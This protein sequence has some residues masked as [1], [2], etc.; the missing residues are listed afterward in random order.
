MNTEVTNFVNNYEIR[1]I[2]HRDRIERYVRTIKPIQ[3]SECEHCVEQDVQS[4]SDGRWNFKHQLELRRLQS[5]ETNQE[6]DP[7]STIRSVVRTEEY[8][9]RGFKPIREVSPKSKT[10]PNSEYTET[11]A[12]SRTLEKEEITEA[13]SFIQ[14]ERPQIR[15]DLSRQSTECEQAHCKPSF[16]TQFKALR[17][18]E[19]PRK[20][21]I[22][23]SPIE[24]RQE[25]RSQNVN[26]NNQLDFKQPITFPDSEQTE[27]QEDYQTIEP[28]ESNS[29]RIEAKSSTS[30]RTIRVKVKPG[31]AITKEE[32]KSQLKNA[33]RSV[34]K[35][36]PSTTRA[37][38]IKVS[39]E[40]F[41]R[42]RT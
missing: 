24:I 40:Y 30:R 2:L 28:L 15:N 6:L 27:R 12:K 39:S 38:D 26:D 17:T 33:K 35:A 31:T 42:K 37:H 23:L 1:H 8:I 21:P 10:I 20:S 25:E 7:K 9:R 18:I 3:Q 5:T 36:Q 22:H 32:L 11:R 4:S 29:K 34:E 13:K 41:N 14:H 19:T 16:T